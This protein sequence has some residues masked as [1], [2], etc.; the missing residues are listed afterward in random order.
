[1]TA[2]LETFVCYCQFI[3]VSCQAAFHFLRRDQSS[4]CFG[5]NLKLHFLLIR[6]QSNEP[7][8]FSFRFVCICSHYKFSKYLSLQGYA[9]KIQQ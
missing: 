4:I 3:L 8:I 1:M 6:W 2:L 9:L 7:K 5:V